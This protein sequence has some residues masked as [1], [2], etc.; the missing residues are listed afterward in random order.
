MVM[1]TRPF[2]C[3]KSLTESELIIALPAVHGNVFWVVAILLLSI[4]QLGRERERE[5]ERGA[6]LAFIIFRP[7]LPFPIWRRVV[8]SLVG[9]N[10]STVAYKATPSIPLPSISASATARVWVSTFHKP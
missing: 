9:V 1:G 5:G 3:A 4:Y 6:R 10:A 7:S 2:Y 8:I